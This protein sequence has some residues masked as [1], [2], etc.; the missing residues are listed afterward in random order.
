VCTYLLYLYE[1]LLVCQQKV[2]HVMYSGSVHCTLINIRIW[3]ICL[4]LY[5][6]LIVNRKTVF[7]VIYNG[8]VNVRRL[9]LGCPGLQRCVL[10]YEVDS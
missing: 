7:I 2:I 6:V 4:K 10:H 5:F 1:V 8:T 9:E 3:W